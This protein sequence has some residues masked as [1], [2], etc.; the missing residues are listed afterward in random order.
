MPHLIN[1]IP[2]H[3]GDDRYHMVVEIPSGTN[4]KWQTDAQSGEQYWDQLDGKNR[5]IRF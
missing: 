5:V 2:V 4:D 3:A 1:D